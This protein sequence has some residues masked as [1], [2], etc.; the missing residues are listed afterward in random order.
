ML[1]PLDYVIDEPANQFDFQFENVFL[2][3]SQYSLVEAWIINNET[4][5]VICIIVYFFQTLVH[6]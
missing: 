6:K 3:F 1:L 5:Q 2:F 4:N